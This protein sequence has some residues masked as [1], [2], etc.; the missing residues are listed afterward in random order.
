MYQMA[1]MYFKWPKNIPTFSIPRPSKIYPH[2]DL[3]LENIP[4]GN[5]ATVQKASVPR[6]SIERRIDSGDVGLMGPMVSG[7]STVA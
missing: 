5:P 1:V 7:P 2:C 3:W 6:L 4:S